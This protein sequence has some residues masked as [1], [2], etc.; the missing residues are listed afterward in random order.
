MGKI[1]FICICLWN[2]VEL[3]SITS[4][5]NLSTII[6][7][8]MCWALAAN[9]CILFLSFLC[10]EMFFA[11]SHD[12]NSCQ[13]CLSGQKLTKPKKAVTYDLYPNGWGF[14]RQ[15]STWAHKHWVPNWHSFI[16][17]QYSRWNKHF[18]GLIIPLLDHL[19]HLPE[20]ISIL[21]RVDIS[22]MQFSCNC[23]ES[24]FGHVVSEVVGLWICVLSS[25]LKYNQKLP[26]GH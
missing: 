22:E 14:H 4:Y 5:T 20:A 15:K 8:W 18:G 19:S 13:G 7:Y 10:T 2:V 1:I 11:L 17:T 3:S 12:A 24:L 21:R 26:H 23:L 6:D 16:K 9:W 25:N